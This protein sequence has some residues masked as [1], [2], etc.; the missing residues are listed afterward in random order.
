MEVIRIPGYT[1]DEKL[2]IA[3]RYL[4]PKQMKQNGLKADEL[5]FS[6]QALLDIIRYYTREAGC[7]PLSVRLPR[8][9]ARWSRPSVSSEQEAS[10]DNRAGYARRSVRVSGSSPSAVAEEENQIGQVT[11]LAWTSV[12]GELLTIEAVCRVRQGTP[13]SR[14]APWA[15]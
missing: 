2:N 15:M 1:E 14:P 11:G 6:S 3:Q 9:A 13:W 4:I 7:A 8:S 12:G 10:G 5:E